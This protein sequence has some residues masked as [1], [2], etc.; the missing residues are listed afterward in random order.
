MSENPDITKYFN[1]EPGNKS[2]Q[3]FDKINTDQVAVAST[4]DKCEENV[5]SADKDDEPVVCKIFQ[6]SSTKKTFEADPS[7]FFDMIGAIDNDLSKF[8]HFSFTFYAVDTQKKAK[9]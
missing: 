7:N 4:V 1:D 3:F 6:S 2:T 9:F 8:L 5:G